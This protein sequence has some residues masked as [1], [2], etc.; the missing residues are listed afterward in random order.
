MRTVKEVSE[1]SGISVRTLHY[2]DE[3]GLLTPTEINEAGYRLYD[4]KAIERLQRILYFREFDLPLKEIKAIMDHPNL[5]MDKLLADQRKLL[6]AKKERLEKL[7][8]SIDDILKGENKMDFEVFSK[9][10]LEE[11]FQDIMKIYSEEQLQVLVRNFGSIEEYKEQYIANV[12]RPSTQEHMAK[13]VEW[14][15]DKELVKEFMTNPGSS[16]IGK[17]YNNRIE[18][19]YRKIWEKKQQGVP[20]T[21]FQVKSLVGELDYVIKE[22]LQ[23]EDASLKN[24]ISAYRTNPELMEIKHKAFGPGMAEYMADAIEAFCGEKTEKK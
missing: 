18:D 23:V 16:K 12:S 20:V 2:Y 19:I 3:I 15:G 11:V 9:A 6:N 4:D 14:Y 1:I 24:L 22:F 21:D 17:A 13:M 8:A 5:D 10:E 7:V